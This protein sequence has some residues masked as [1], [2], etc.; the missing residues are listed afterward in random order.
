MEAFC[1]GFHKEKGKYICIYS[2][3]RRLPPGDINAAGSCCL[4]CVATEVVR[5]LTRLK[6]HVPLRANRLMMLRLI[7]LWT[8]GQRYLYF[9]GNFLSGSFRM[10]F[11]FCRD[12]TCSQTILSVYFFIH[13]YSHCRNLV[14]RFNKCGWSSEKP[15][16]QSTAKAYRVSACWML[17]GKQALVGNSASRLNSNQSDF[18]HGWNNSPSYNW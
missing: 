18:F 7:Y 13:C 4:L 5:H 3:L 9:S 1:Y 2:V 14:R 6:Y 17:E 10:P 16:A 11:N 15:R 12:K 8:K